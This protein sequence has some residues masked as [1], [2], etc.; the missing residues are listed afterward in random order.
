MYIL[1]KYI[2][3]SK[4]YLTAVTIPGIF[5]VLIF[6]YALVNN[7]KNIGINM[8]TGIMIIS[9]YGVFNTFISL[10]NPKIVNISE[11]NI[12]FASFGKVHKYERESISSISIREFYDRKMYIRINK[13]GAI[14]GRYWIKTALFNDSNELYKEF[15]DLERHLHPDALKFRS[16]PKNNLN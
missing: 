12:E 6:V 8:Y 3:D 15:N 1:K 4:R 7:F 10:S 11:E 2:Y 16:K 5:M 9:M 14:K 13:G